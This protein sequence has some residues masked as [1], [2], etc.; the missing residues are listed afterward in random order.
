[1]AD[2]FQRYIEKEINGEVFLVKTE[3]WKK[4]QILAQYDTK[5]ASSGLPPHVKNLALSDYIGEDRSIPRKMRKYIAEFE[6]R[7]KDLHLYFWSPENGTQKTTT[8]SIIG[9][10]LLRK[11]LD[12]RFI[13]MGELLRIL[14]DF[15]SS[16][17]DKN[18]KDDLLNC[19]FLILDD[20][21]DKKKATIYK[22]GY[23][24]PFLDIFLRDRLEVQKKATCFTANFSID[25]IDEETFGISLKN[26]V[27]RAVPEPFKFKVL[28]TDRHNFD[29]KDLWS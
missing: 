11:G 18:R 26:L 9:A 13:L 22:S 8:A 4:K 5:F 25:N 17:E 16:E 3:E 27:R 14:S 24:I 10:E 20:C 6:T 1:M 2:D 21:F 23:Q 29:P 19:D 28:Y 15:E 7:Y 12:V